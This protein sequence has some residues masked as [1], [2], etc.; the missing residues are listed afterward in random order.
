MNCRE[1]SPEIGTTVKEELWECEGEIVYSAG[2]ICVCCLWGSVHVHSC[3]Y[4]SVWKVNTFVSLCTEG[5]VKGFLYYNHSQPP[6][7]QTLLRQMEI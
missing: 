5:Y 3:V 7:S 1:L 6:T 2:G 4:I